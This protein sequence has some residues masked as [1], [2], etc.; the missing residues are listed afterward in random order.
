MPGWMPRCEEADIAQWLQQ[1]HLC[2]MPLA[3]L[4]LNGAELPKENRN[5]PL[6]YRTAAEGPRQLLLPC[7]LCDTAGFS[8]LPHTATDVP[9]VRADAWRGCHSPGHHLGLLGECPSCLPLPSLSSALLGEVFLICQRT[10]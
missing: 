4:L 2:V 10:S 7:S 3:V 6:G 9:R 1:E 8:I 5:L